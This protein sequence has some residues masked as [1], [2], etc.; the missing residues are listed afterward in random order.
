MM[1]NIREAGPSELAQIVSLHERAFPDFLL[2]RLGSAFLRTYYEIALQHTGTLALIA[3][4]AKGRTA[5]FLIG[6][7]APQEFY[8]LLTRRKWRLA[9]MAV[10]SMMCSPNLLPRVFGN[11]RRMREAAKPSSTSRLKA[12]LAS[13]GVLPAASG[14]GVGK[15]LVSEFV[16][17]AVARGAKNIYLTTDAENNAKANSFYQKLGFSRYK[18]FLAPGGRLINE[19]VLALEG[20]SGCDYQFTFKL[21]KKP[22]PQ[23]L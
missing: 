3:E 18:T 23:D 21:F 1:I 5:G 20:R 15:A 13:I 2:T 9:W 10:R 6:Y 17:R 7:V 16:Q 12:E 8:T 19:Y 4:E 22:F 11:M 14:R